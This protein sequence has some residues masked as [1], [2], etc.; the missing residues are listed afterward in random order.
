MEP[1]YK[2]NR[3]DN[4]RFRALAVKEAVGNATLDES[5]EL[6]KLS[7]K[8]SRKLNRHPR[9]QE[10][11]RLQRNN[12]RKMKRLCHKMDALIDRSPVLRRAFGRKRFGDAF[13]RS[14]KI[15]G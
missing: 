7:R 12:M 13:K 3:K 14:V 5:V 4:A 9:M 8:R 15:S 11:L 1:K 2:L 6:E 10:S